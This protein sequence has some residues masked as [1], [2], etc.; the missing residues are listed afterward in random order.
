MK[1]K[2]GD[3]LPTKVMKTVSGEAIDLPDPTRLVHLQF[4]RFVDCPICN[5]HIAE[6]RKRVREIESAGVKEVIVFHSSPQSVRSYQKDVPF[7]MV[8]DPKKAFYKEFGVESS[9][10]FMSFKALGAAVRGM[11]H[12]HFGLRPAGGL[13]GLPADFLVA[14]SGRITAVKYGADAFDQWSVDQLLT[15]ATVSRAQAA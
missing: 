9:L 4:R 10:G 8:G 14:P 15:L 1:F 3:M 13:M 2:P 6:F 12:G 5:T 11:A 7:L